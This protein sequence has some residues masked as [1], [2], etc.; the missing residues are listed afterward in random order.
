VDREI[1]VRGDASTR[2]LPDR[3]TLTAVVDGDGATRDEAYV[4]AVEPASAVDAVIE[5]FADAITR[6]F[7][8]ALA[9]QP[10]TRYHKG[11]SKRTGWRATRTSTI[12]VEGLDQ[13]GELTAALATAGAALHGPSW[14]IDRANPA[15]DQ[16]RRA[17][18]IDARSRAAAYASALGLE[19]EAVAWVAEP[20][21]RH[22]P[23][24]GVLFTRASMAGGVSSL[25]DAEVIE[26][27]P[28]EMEVNVAVEV[29]FSFTVA[30]GTGN[31][32]PL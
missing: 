32:K 5:R 6:S 22:E 28:E 2:V 15:Y 4:A 10:L 7:T 19:L 24:E 25:S 23:D 12:E 20:G 18:A 11:E 13:L 17:A 14:H 8:T 16:V 21:L 29:G 3:A 30:S 27:T 26:V 9:V 1:V 31:P